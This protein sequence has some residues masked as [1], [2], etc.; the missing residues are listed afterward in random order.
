[1]MKSCRSLLMIIG[2][3]SL[4]LV[5][6]ITGL[7]MLGST[8]EKT[9]EPDAPTS[10]PADIAAPPTVDSADVVP[11]PPSVLSPSPE[12]VKPTHTPPANE[13]TQRPVSITGQERAYLR[14]VAGHVK[15]LIDAM[16][17]LS[18]LFENPTFTE[19]WQRAVAVNIQTIRSA[20]VEVVQLENPPSL[21]EIHFAIV[22]GTAACDDMTY[23]LASGID[24]QDS[25]LIDLAAQKLDS[26]N[27]RILDAA[28]MIQ[29]W[30]NERE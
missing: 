27:T 10:A 2:G 24:Q 9:D 7:T 14:A 4:L 8:I 26:C 17:R 29:A 3:F 6:A 5:C 13:A 25:T 16:S 20:H 23:D 18:R 22:D 19:T 28:A 30:L 15:D 1:M 11:T 12:L 21:A